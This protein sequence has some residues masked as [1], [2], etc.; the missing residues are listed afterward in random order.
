[1]ALKVE[2][3]DTWAASIEDKPGSLAA[4]LNALTGAGVNLEFVIARRAPEKPG[5]GVVFVTPVQGAAQTRVAREVGFE[6]TTSLHT[7]RIEGP[8]KPGHGL[9]IAEALSAHG[10]NLRGFTAAAIGNRFVAH[11]ALDSASDAAK[12]LRVL[13]RP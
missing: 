10:L 11:V 7:V 13:R 5:S 1:M 4:K 6:K 8:N 9:N 2:R 3:V 12:A